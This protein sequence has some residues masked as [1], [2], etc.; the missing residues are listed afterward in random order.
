MAKLGAF[1]HV[2]VD[3]SSIFNAHPCCPAF[4]NH[5]VAAPILGKP[6]VKKATIWVSPEIVLGY[7]VYLGSRSTRW[8]F[9]LHCK[10]CIDK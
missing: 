7:S 1:I 9:Q 5:G 8:R 6:H 3:A 10:N 4:R 2:R